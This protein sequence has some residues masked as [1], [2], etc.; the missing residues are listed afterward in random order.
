M[1]HFS[2]SKGARRN[3]DKDPS[4]PSLTLKST[5]EAEVTSY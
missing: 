4:E 1:F 2:A 3:V 5:D